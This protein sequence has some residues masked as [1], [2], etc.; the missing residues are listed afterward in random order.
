MSRFYFHLHDA[1]GYIPDEEGRELESSAD[2]QVVAVM[3]AR[4]IISAEVAEGRLDLRGRIEVTDD[5]GLR[6]AVIPF[7]D[8]VEVLSGQLPPE[9]R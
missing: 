4:S 3:G 6:L 8:V 9:N 5:Q 2:A 7:R 1:L